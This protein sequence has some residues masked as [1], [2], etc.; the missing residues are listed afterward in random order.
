M[1]NRPG[2]LTLRARLDLRRMLRP[3]VQPGSTLEYALPAEEVTLTFTSSGPIEVETPDGTSS[4][5][6][7]VEEQDRFQA[8]V[9]RTT[10]E[11]ELLDLVVSLEMKTPTTLEVTFK[12]DEDDRPRA[13]PIRRFLVPWADLADSSAAESLVERT[14]PELEG[15]DWEHGR[16]LFFGEL[17]RCADCHQVR[18][19]G[20]EI[21]PDLSNLIHR[22]Y[23]S[24]LR[25]IQAPSA[26][27][28]PDFIT[29][30]V[31]LNDGRVLQGTLRSE[32]DRL[33]ISDTD[34]QQTNVDRSEV[35]ATTPSGVSIMP[36]GID[37]ALGPDRLRDLLTFLLTDPI[38]PAP[39]EA[40]GAPPPRLRS[41]VEAIQKDSAEVVAP[42]PLRIVLV[43]GPKDHGP[44]EHDY[45]LWQRRWSDLLAMAEGVLVSIADGWPDA[46]QLET[47]D[48]LV[49]YS[50]NPGWSEDRAEALD[51]YLARG[52]GLVLIHYAVDGHNAV[53]ALADRIGLAWKGGA[54]RFRHGE[55]KVD[56]SGSSHPITRNFETLTLVDESYWNLVGDPDTVELLG[57]GVE[58][59][60][61]RPLF[62]TREQGEGRVFV[63][64]P[65]H[66]NWTF[67]DP[68]FRLLIL[69]G[70]AWVAKEPVDRF[71]DLA[72][73]GARIRD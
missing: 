60:A 8:Q 71:N 42:S 48:V 64:I 65:G 69:R 33:I 61:P 44:G 36:E 6:A 56:F 38:E 51:R 68:L 12:T 73:L 37:E 5:E 20:R 34:G 54:S 14:I 39:I 22:D 72:T 45:P 41:E 26:A 15:G 3:E 23:D 30:N 40:E 13:L 70:M 49:L 1:L 21:G 4:G 47:A 10:Q 62:W 16:E 19:R 24:V 50:N 29:H 7:V 11:D 58:D 35:E 43:A 9:T 27:I 18:G 67:D 32:G 2:R 25:D 55:L 17:A 66:F 63:S 46:D 31:A 28:N 59:G 52:G 57:Q 53:E